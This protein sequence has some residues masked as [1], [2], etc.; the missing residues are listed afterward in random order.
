MESSL[1]LPIDSVASIGILATI[2]EGC[3]AATG[4]LS[5][6]I[7]RLK[8]MN[9]HVTVDII[10]SLP[11]RARTGRDMNARAGC[12]RAFFKYT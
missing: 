2:L 5:A 10:V 12:F 3:S 4:R 9:T 8:K 1:S 6:L 7:I 11:L